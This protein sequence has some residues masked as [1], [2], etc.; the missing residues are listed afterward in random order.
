VIVFV[1][2]A[3]PVRDTSAAADVRDDARIHVRVTGRFLHNRESTVWA[4]GL[5]AGRR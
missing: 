4:N 5:G 3:I 2:V 1:D